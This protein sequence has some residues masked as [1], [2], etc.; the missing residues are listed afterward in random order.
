[1]LDGLSAGPRSSIWSTCASDEPGPSTS[2]CFGPRSG[3]ERRMPTDYGPERGGCSPT[4]E[5]VQRSVPAGVYPRLTITSVMSSAGA[6]NASM[7]ARIAS[8]ISRAER[9]FTLCS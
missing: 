3:A 9:C 1:M 7:S 8:H 4:L 5:P 2:P 6:L